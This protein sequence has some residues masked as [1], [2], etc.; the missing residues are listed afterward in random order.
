M[1]HFG[2]IAV[3]RYSIAYFRAAYVHQRRLDNVSL[4]F[5]Y[6]LAAPGF[7][8]FSEVRRLA[9]GPIHGR[10]ITGIDKLGNLV[11]ISQIIDSVGAAE[12]MNRS[13][14]AIVGLKLPYRCKCV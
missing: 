10:Q 9:A 3:F 7:L 14:A 5:F 6:T 12:P 4:K 13:P 2:N 1:Q 11:P 8:E